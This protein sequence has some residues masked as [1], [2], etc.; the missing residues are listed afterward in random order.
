[1]FIVYFVVEGLV[2]MRKKTKDFLTVVFLFLGA[3]MFVLLL[4]S[5]FKVI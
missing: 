4:L 5:I 3:V 2:N 1:M